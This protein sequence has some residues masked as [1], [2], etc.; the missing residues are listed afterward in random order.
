ML[1]R[2]QL[3]VSE[4]KKL[5]ND[6][7]QSFSFKF[8]SFFSRLEVLESNSTSSRDKINPSCSESDKDPE[9]NEEEDPH[10]VAQV[11]DEKIFFPR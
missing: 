11:S 10:S 8:Q 9:E 3:V 2:S 7:M 5:L 1:F 6:F 4:D